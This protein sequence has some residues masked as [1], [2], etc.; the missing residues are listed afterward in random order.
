MKTMALEINILM[1]NFQRDL[2]WLEMHSLFD[3][4]MS[5]LPFLGE[6]EPFLKLHWHGSL[7]DL[8][9]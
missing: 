6:Q 9:P 2:V 7:S 8:W 4:Q 3:S 1:L 5:V